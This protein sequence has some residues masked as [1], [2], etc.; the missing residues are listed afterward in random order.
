MAV[1]FIRVGGVYAVEWT[2]VIAH[3]TVRK[4]AAQTR[5]RARPDKP[6]PAGTL[7]LP[8]DAAS[9]RFYV[10]PEANI[11]LIHDPYRGTLCGT[12]KVGHPAY[13]LLSPDAQRQR[14]LMWG[15]AIASLAQSSACAGLQVSRVD[16]SRQWQGASP[17]TTTGT[18]RVRAGGCE[19]QY[20]ALLA[21][22]ATGASTHRTTMTLGLDMQRAAAAIKAAGGGSAGRREGAARGDG[23]PRIRAANPPS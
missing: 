22:N 17:T 23:R 16:D 2:P 20:Q 12:L 13:A 10:E 7:A 1:A 18:E 19:E 6:R 9:L 14:V 15:R 3:W 4:R 8:G 11:C 5:Y 21:D